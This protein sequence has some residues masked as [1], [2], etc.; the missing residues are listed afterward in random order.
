M[1]PDV[2]NGSEQGIK[3]TFASYVTNI[4]SFDIVLNSYRKHITI[5]TNVKY[6]EKK[7]VLVYI[8]FSLVKISQQNFILRLYIDILK[9]Q[10]AS[11]VLMKVNNIVTSFCSHLN[12]QFNMLAATISIQQSSS[13]IYIS[14][15]LSVRLCKFL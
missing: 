7:L 1:Q 14:K 11:H 10:G 8:F 2:R 6:C 12:S 9:N 13:K 4:A 3:I 15:K 5:V